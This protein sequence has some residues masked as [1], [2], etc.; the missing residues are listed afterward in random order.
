M[1]LEYDKDA[2][3]A[4]IRLDNG[5]FSRNLVAGNIIV[6]INKKGNIQGIEILFATKMLRKETLLNA[7]RI[8]KKKK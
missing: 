5:K 2:N 1:K 6:D 8:D 7:I 3:A 4:Y